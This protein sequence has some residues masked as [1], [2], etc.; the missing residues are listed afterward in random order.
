MKAT[1]LRKLGQYFEIKIE[2]VGIKLFYQNETLGHEDYEHNVEL[3]SN[4]ETMRIDCWIDGAEDITNFDEVEF[5]TP[6]TNGDFYTKF[7]TMANLLHEIKSY[8]QKVKDLRRTLNTGHLFWTTKEINHN[9]DIYQRVIN[10]LSQRYY[11]IAA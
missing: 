4:D 5:I 1:F 2:G 3:V 10:R 11:K 6:D 7:D 8:K 9:I